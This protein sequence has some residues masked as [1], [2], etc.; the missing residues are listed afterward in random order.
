M[1][2][3]NKHIIKIFATSDLLTD[4]RV[5]RIAETLQA[6]GYAVTTY[7]RKTQSKSKPLSY[8]YQIKR[9][10]T[11]FNKGILFF[12]TYNF[13]IFG[14]LLFSRYSIIYANDLD[15]L[16]GCSMASFVRRKPLVY[17]SHEFFTE[18]PELI[19]H[20]IK[21][22]IWKL[23]EKFCIKRAR[24]VI[25]V[26]KGIATLL[27][28]SYG[29]SPLVIRNV[30][31][32]AQH[33]M[34]NKS[35]IPTIIYQGYLNVG[36][37]IELIMN[38]LQYL[39]NYRLI[40]AGRGD[41]ETN[42]KQL[43]KTLKINDRIDFLGMLP[44]NELRSTTSQAWI[45]ISLEEDLGLNYHY[46]LPNKLFDYIAAQIPVLVSNLPEMKQIVDEYG[47]GIVAESRNPQKIANQI[48]SYF[49]NEGQQKSTVANLLHASQVLTWES[50]EKKLID[51]VTQI[52]G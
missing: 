38:T 32:R 26:S 43:A 14:I 17:D 11:P 6:Q 22:G 29:V 7:G 31:L 18:I 12:L 37:G 25:S 46:A 35:S 42:L 52:L 4:Q 44:P 5:N 8:S 27:N 28:Q 9:I 48:N 21:K 10:C 23:V 39:P 41:I 51:A 16:L 36:R 47:V 3:H 30:P 15:T 19:G 45:G 40:I 34:N 50:E 24:V 1:K 13:K 33:N 20:K 2:P 49:N